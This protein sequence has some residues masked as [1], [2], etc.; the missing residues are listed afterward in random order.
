MEHA[1]VA[2]PADHIKRVATAIYTYVRRTRT[3]PGALALRAR[4]APRRARQHRQPRVRPEERDVSGPTHR[5]AHARRA[6]REAAGQPLGRL[7]PGS[8]AVSG[9]EGAKEHALRKSGYTNHPGRRGVLALRRDV[10]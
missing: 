3:R 1:P 5:H 6:L 4:A 10:R 2:A 7:G 9:R 8:G